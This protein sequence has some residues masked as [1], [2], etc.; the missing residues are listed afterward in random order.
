MLKLRVRSQF[1]SQSDE[2]GNVFSDGRVKAKKTYSAWNPVFTVHL[3]KN[4]WEEKWLVSGV[5]NS[6]LQKCV[7]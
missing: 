1:Y 3:Q 4:N 6:K 5:E 7:E 2:R